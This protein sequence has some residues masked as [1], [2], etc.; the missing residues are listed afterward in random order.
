MSPRTP[1]P[2]VDVLLIE[3]D[4]VLCTLLIHALR[5]RDLAVDVADDVVE[6]K[7]LLSR[8]LYKVALIDLV[9][10]DGDGYEVIDFIRSSGPTDMHSIVITGTDSSALGQLDRSVAKNVFFK[11]LDVEHLAGFVQMLTR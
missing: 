3:D 7:R 5:G 8:N 4:D 10:R 1:V 9:L 11:P 6:S 2:A